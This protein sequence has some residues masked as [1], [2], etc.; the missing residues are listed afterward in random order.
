MRQSNGFGLLKIILAGALWSFCCPALAQIKADDTLNTSVRSEGN[1]FVIEGGRTSNNQRNLFHS[2]DRFSLSENDT[3]SFRVNAAVSN[4]FARVTGSFPSQIDGRIEVFQ[5]NGT[6][7]SANL[8]LLNPRGIIFGQN[9]SLNVGGSFLATTGDRLTFDNG[10]QFK[11]DGT[12][13]G[14]LLT[15]SVPTGIQFGKSSSSIQNTS[16]FQ[17]DGIIRDNNGNPVPIPKIYDDGIDTT[18]VGLAVPSGETLALMGNN[19]V[20]NE[21]EL[22]AAA[23]HI[24]L[25]SIRSGEVTLRQT[26]GRW[27]FGYNGVNQ[28]GNIRISD[29]ADV[30]ASG[31][32][33][34]QVHLWGG[35]IQ[36]IGGSQIRSNTLSHQDGQGI[37]IHSSQLVL[38]DYGT[39]ISAGTFGSG[40]GG[41]IA[42]QTDQLMIED[43]AQVDNSTYATGQGGNVVIRSENSIELRDAGRSENGTLVLSDTRRPFPSGVYLR[44]YDAGY[45]GTLSIATDR[46]SLEGGA[47]VATE[48]FG[49]GAAG[50]MTIHALDIALEGVVLQ[51]NGRPHTIQQQDGR[52]PFPSA[53]ST[54]TNSRGRAGN[55]EISTDRLRLSNGAALQTSTQS[56]G[57]AGDLSIEATEFIELSGTAK[58]LDAPTSLLTFSGGIPEISLGN[59]NATGRGGDLTIRTNNFSIRDGAAIAVGSLNPNSDVRSAGQ[60]IINAQAVQL[61]QQ[62]RLTAASASGDGGSIVLQTRDDLTLGRGSN[63]STTA[64]ARGRGGNGGNIVISAHTVNAAPGENSDITAQAFSGRGGNIFIFTRQPIAGLREGHSDP[65]NSTN[66]IDAS[67]QFGKSGTVSLALPVD[68]ELQPLT[69]ASAEPVQGCQVAGGQAIASFFNT[70]HGG[71]PPTPYEP[72]SSA[73]ILDDVRLPSQDSSAAAPQSRSDRAIVEANGWI[74]GDDGKV[75]LMAAAPDTQPQ[76]LCHLR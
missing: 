39:L 66:D 46:L 41:N 27:V 50:S 3:A 19:V 32:G 57:D 22:T 68:T 64:G 59:P 1:T 17:S 69:L 12:Q 51:S 37:F 67:S 7:S 9:A 16:F 73:E 6:I 40:S 47:Q 34:G 44:A 38:Q 2:F 10:A 5:T 61:D 4:V 75:V 25:A 33:G 62:A 20:L 18:L 15:V 60:L 70:S 35:N 21:G 54:F 29:H 13:S 14:S 26:N 58:G 53:L 65:S 8:F 36:L 45:S 63:I 48:A 30:D 55:L 76:G 11:A 28:F 42:L 52:V 72:L 24:E 56:S 43:G 74:V 23:G 71:L 49:R 31:A